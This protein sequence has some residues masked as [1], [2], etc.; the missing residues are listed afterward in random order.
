MKKI[1]VTGS[2][3]YI[4]SHFIQEARKF[5]KEF[6]I[7]STSKKKQTKYDAKFIPFDILSTTD[8][9][10]LYSI[11]EKPD[12]CVHFAW[13]DGF[14]HNSV[15]HI[16]DMS[17]HFLFLK[18]LADL[19]VKHFVVCGSF[20]EYGKVN[21]LV[22]ANI[23]V[24]PSTLYTLSKMTLKKSLEIYFENKDICL[25][26]IRPF[27]VYG[28]DEKT[29]SL[30]SKIIKWEK[31]NKAYFPF[32][33]GKEE[34]DYIH[35]DILSMMITAIISQETI[36]GEIDCCSGYPRKLGEM[37]ENFIHENNFKIKPQ[38]NAFQRREYDS[39]CIYGNTKKIMEIFSK[40]PLYDL[41][42]ID[43]KK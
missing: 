7:I 32:T 27:T 38:Y 10:D 15:N 8:S 11:F 26:W 20:R 1:L 14:V 41:N 30:F 39:P 36:Q 35:I 21:G 6:E 4:G 37:V 18:K 3:G 40:S 12:I 25:Q 43:I 13:R 2:N 5:P 17:K 16:L 28:D 34:Y 9:T 24:I 22:N 31:E 42:N 23:D 29:N 33:D 19:G